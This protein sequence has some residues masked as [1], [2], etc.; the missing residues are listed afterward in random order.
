MK[1]F[2]GLLVF[3][4]ILLAGCKDKKP[5]KAPKSKTPA[6]FK[7]QIESK[8]P[9]CKIISTA[10]THNV[11]VNFSRGCWEKGTGYLHMASIY[12]YKRRRMAAF[13]SSAIML[14]FMGGRSDIVQVHHQCA[15]ADKRLFCIT[16][17]RVTR[18]R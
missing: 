18:A 15:M 3:L 7:V 12:P 2:L 10:R 6:S 11:D 14:N 8:Y 16:V 1:K 4:A 9:G 17:H 5:A 13:D